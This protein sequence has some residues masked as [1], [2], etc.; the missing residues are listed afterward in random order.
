MDIVL[1][2]LGLIATILLAIKEERN[3][4][5]YLY[6]VIGGSIMSFVI[7]TT[8]I[9]IQLKNIEKM[10]VEHVTELHDIIDNQL[11]QQLKY[12]EYEKG[13]MD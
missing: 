9:D 5:I 4:R 2:I 10:Y 1:G 13:R 11:E 8:V 3:Y 6:G 7:T 12:I